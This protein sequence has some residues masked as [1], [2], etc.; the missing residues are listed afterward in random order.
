M[1]FLVAF[2]LVLTDCLRETIGDLLLGASIVILFL[3]PPVLFLRTVMF[4]IM[5]SSPMI[6]LFDMFREVLDRDLRRGIGSWVRMPS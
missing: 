4:V 1:T 3:T 6:F 2:L 5:P